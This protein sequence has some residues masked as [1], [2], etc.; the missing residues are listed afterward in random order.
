MDIF[1]QAANRL[2]SVPSING[3]P[4]ACD[5][6]DRAA[7]GQLRDWYLP[8]LACEAVGGGSEAALPTV[9]AIAA[10]QVSIILIDDCLDDDPKGEYRQMGM[11]ATANLAAALQAAAIE[12]VIRAEPGLPAQTLLAIIA[13]INRMI[14]DTAL[15][16]YLDGQPVLDDN[17]YWRVVSLKSSPFFAAA[18]QMGAL[19]GGASIRDAETLG[20]IGGIYGE[21][22]QLHDDLAD[23]MALP[24]KPDWTQP[25]SPLPILFAQ[26]ANH[27]ERA[28]FLQLREQVTD[29]AAIKNAQDILI[30]CG[31]LSY[32]VYQLLNR[33]NRGLKLL[34]EMP[35]V[36]KAGIKTLLDNSARPACELLRKVGVS[37]AEI[38]RLLTEIKG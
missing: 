8:V 2:K 29:L 30:R 24:P 35:L 31:A 16:Q 3:W 33:Y 38:A 32:V 4:I 11:P 17:G 5:L 34:D 27:P 23:C 15:G 26:T 36:H 37:D 25:R 28:R 22:I 19:I 13:S 9:A 10:A 21:M 6:I 1:I 20:Q 18:M 7:A 14:V 12:V